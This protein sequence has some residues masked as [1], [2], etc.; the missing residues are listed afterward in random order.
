MTTPSKPATKKNLPEMRATISSD[1][2]DSASG[3][4]K[5]KVAVTIS[6]ATGA[7]TGANGDYIMST[8]KINDKH[9]YQQIEQGGRTLVPMHI[10]YDGADSN[11]WVVTN[12]LIRPKESRVG[13]IAGIDCLT[14]DGNK[15][16]D[17]PS[18]S[19]KTGWYILESNG[20]KTE[21][22]PNMKAIVYTDVRPAERESAAAAS[23]SPAAT[24]DVVVAIP[25]SI[26]EM[27]NIYSEIDTQQE[28]IS[29]KFKN[30]KEDST[31][32]DIE[33][34]ET[35]LDT[36]IKELRVAQ[37][38][39]D[40]YKKGAAATP[41]QTKLNDK[42]R[43]SIIEESLRAIHN[44]DGLDGGRS[45]SS[46]KKNRKS[47]KSYHPGIGKTRKHHSHSEPKRIS[48]VHQA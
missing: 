33:S 6:G 18:L 32:D 39:L 35:E 24:P 30:L 23:S 7:A 9:L 34:F 19:N 28:E 41:D 3:N 47:H 27:R 42:D 11:R 1:S 26:E 37:Q 29:K 22:I 31:I 13:Y 48:F 25:K 45:S 46:S 17:F 16:C 40:E 36:K 12:E 15:N 10:L 5:F 4:D 8:Q 21:S 44:P 20:T 14:T 38:K 2:S 43:E